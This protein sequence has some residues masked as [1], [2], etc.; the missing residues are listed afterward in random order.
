ME[1]SVVK[2]STQLYLPAVIDDFSSSQT[3]HSPFASSLPICK[4]TCELFD[5]L[6]FS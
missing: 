3:N 6:S 1:P 5:N 4:K 2:V